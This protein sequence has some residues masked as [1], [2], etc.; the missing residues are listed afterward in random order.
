M[1]RPKLDK[2]CSR[3]RSRKSQMKR[4]HYQKYDE[5]K[6]RNAI[7][8]IERGSSIRETA[9]KFNIPRVTLGDE[10]K[11]YKGSET[12]NIAAYLQQRSSR[13]VLLTAEEEEAVERYAIWQ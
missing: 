7:V 11:K 4:G 6:I 10:Y 8:M 9:A 2:R 12:T 5:K 13:L 3:N 1:V